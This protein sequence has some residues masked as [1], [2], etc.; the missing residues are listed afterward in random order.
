MTFGMNTMPLDAMLAVSVIMRSCEGG[1]APVQFTV[2]LCMVKGV[3]VVCRL[4]LCVAVEELALPL[5]VGVEGSI[6]DP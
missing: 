5:H 6:L 4:Y 3:S 2:G 1:A